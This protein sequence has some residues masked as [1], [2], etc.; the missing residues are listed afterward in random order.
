MCYGTLVNMKF[1]RFDRVLGRRFP[2]LKED[3]FAKVI[4]EYHS[5]L[6]ANGMNKERVSTSLGKVATAL[7]CVHPGL[8]G[9]P[10]YG[11]ELVHYFRF[12]LA[13]NQQNVLFQDCAPQEFLHVLWYLPEWNSQGFTQPGVVLYTHASNPQVSTL[14]SELEEAL[15]DA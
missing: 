13:C 10:F 8:R 9:K 6:T 1:P 12:A 4:L 15:R 3:P 14:S 2:V 11:V 5:L 7:R